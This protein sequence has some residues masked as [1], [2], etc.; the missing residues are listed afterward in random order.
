MCVCVCVCVCVC[1]RVRCGPYLRHTGAGVGVAGG[2]VAES[3]QTGQDEVDGADLQS[4]AAQQHAII[5]GQRS[6][7]EQSSQ[8][9]ERQRGQHIGWRRLQDMT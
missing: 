3:W 5:S 6:A 1:A 2:V 8:D 7:A 9:V 4:H